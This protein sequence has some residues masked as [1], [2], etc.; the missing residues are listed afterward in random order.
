LAEE[1][2][3]AQAVEW[4]QRAT[5]FGYFKDPKNREH[6]LKAPI[7]EGIRPRTDFGQIKFQ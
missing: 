2:Y 6:L 7:L 3:A 4:L 5:L 1:I